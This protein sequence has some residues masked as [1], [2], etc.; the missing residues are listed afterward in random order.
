[1]KIY[2]DY[3]CNKIL[4]E[5]EAKESVRQNVINDT[6]GLLEFIENNYSYE[7]ILE[8]LE[9]EFLEKVIEERVESWLNKDEYFLV[10]EFSD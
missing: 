6:Y 3:D 5:K 8:N 7:E 1:M 9:P 10:R 2:Y 4:T